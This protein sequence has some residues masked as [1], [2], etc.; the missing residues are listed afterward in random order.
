MLNVELLTEAQYRHASHYL[1]QLKT[2][3]ESF[4]GD[5]INEAFAKF[6]RDWL[7]IQ[8]GHA[9]ASAQGDDPRALELLGTFAIQGLEL[10]ELRQN[11]PDR[12][13]WLQQGLEAAHKLDDLTAQAHHHLQLA[14]V[15]L[16]TSATEQ[17]IH[18]AEQAQAIANR[19]DNALT[20]A[21]ALTVLSN[22]LTRKGDYHTAKTNLERSL[23]IA[24]EIGDQ[25]TEAMNLGNLGALET[26][27][28][29]YETAL[30]YQRQSLAANRE[31]GNMQGMAKALNNLGSTSW[32]IGR[33][34][35]AEAYYKDCLRIREDL[36][37]QTGI[38][39]VMNNL[40]TIAA[41]QGKFDL[42]R[43]RWERCL[44]ISQQHNLRRLIGYTML[45]LG[46]VSRDMGDYDAGIDYYQR[47]LELLREINNLYG[48]S[49]ALCSLGHLLLKLE[50]YDE[51]QAILCEALESG[52]KMGVKP[53]IL[54]A[55]VGLAHLDCTHGQVERGAEL[56]GM[57]EAHPTSKDQNVQTALKAVYP[58]LHE[59]L[60]EHKL[61][62]ALERGSRSNFEDV[63]GD[64]LENRV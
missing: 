19:L 39:D 17:G 58:L 62:L 27:L 53:I 12:V 41:M 10:L 24:R 57:V 5:Q 44:S 20:L 8:R 26:H 40:G 30:V 7:Q 52:Q 61:H 3:T 4:K 13:C 45:N 60:P 43:Q 34:E 9:W 22:H 2:A 21:R 55:I 37:D 50:R 56:V 49:V 23:E 51:A 48:I 46:S 63:V 25:L 31:I 6:E 18:H 14:R 38:A 1:N 35:E 32:S 28:G 47:S 11:T 15:Y 64:L 54:W 59:R 29:N 36:N 33:F 42:A 16:V